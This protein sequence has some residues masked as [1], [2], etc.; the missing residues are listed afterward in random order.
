MNKSPKPDG[1]EED[2]NEGISDVPVDGLID[3][4]PDGEEKGFTEENMRVQMKVSLKEH[5]TESQKVY[6][7]ELKMVSLEKICWSRT[8]FDRWDIKWT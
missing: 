7:M 5:P 3:G 1:L 2:S 8:W 4:I 6:Q